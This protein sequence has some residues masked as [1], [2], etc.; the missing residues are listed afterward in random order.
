M[1]LPIEIV[2]KEETAALLK[3][4]L[5]KFSQFFYKY[6]TGRDFIVSQPLGRES[7]HVTVCKSFTDLFRTQRD[8]YG[9]LINMP[10]GYGKSILTSMFVCWCYAHYADCNFLYISY[11]KDLAT[12][13]TEFIRSVMSS[14]IYS[15][16]FDVHIARD[17][18]AKDNFKTLEGGRLGAFG[19]AGSITGMNAGLPG[20]ERFSGAVI[21]D[22]AHKPIEVHSETLRKK[23]IDQYSETILQ[24][25]RDT[26]VPFIFIGQRL[27][28]QDLAAHLLSGDDV[29]DWHQL[30]LR[31]LDA[32]GNALFPEAQSKEY[33]ESL[34]DKQ[35][36]VFA[37]QI[38]QDPLPAGGALFKPEW[39]VIHDEE[40]EI[41]ATFITGDTA[42]TEKTYN[43][44]TVFS[45]FGI[46]E[47]ELFGKKTGDLALHWLDCIE[48]YVE[49]KDLQ[50][51]FL[52]FVADCSRHSLPPRTIAIEKKSTGV[53]LLSTIR[54]VQGLQIKGINRTVASG[55]K[56]S[57]FLD[58]QSFIAERRIS[59]TRHAKH[60]DMCKL[61]MS[62][63]TANNTHRRDDIADTLAD[64]IKIA[65][66]DKSIYSVKS[67]TDASD[68]IMSDL[69]QSIRRRSNRYDYTSR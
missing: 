51:T 49:P 34:Q 33:L 40:P 8:H 45:F 27:H 57:R 56:T 58:I 1:T 48:V 66:I 26:N 69:T 47:I 11:S 22:D 50:Q 10:P 32:A 55:N 52:D 9:L 36:Y 5:L 4:S 63:I 17:S 59:F 46:Y 3:G 19:S 43:D 39:F 13:H 35:P 14:A 15:D 53:T 28:E 65:L 31:G 62:K 20:L 38:Q 54:D 6:I 18:R 64:G 61:H 24:R 60:I 2:E 42:E 68:K 41:L 67:S 25:P 44:A 30:I 29:R 16:L 12:I 23:V 37:S 7:H 21:I